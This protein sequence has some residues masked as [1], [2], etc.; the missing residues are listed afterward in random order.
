MQAGTM[1]VEE[2][3]ECNKG[4]GWIG[5]DLDGTLAAWT[6]WTRW[7][8]FGEPIAPMVDRVRAWV[9]DGHVVKIFTA[10]LDDG[11]RHNTC[12]K[13]GERFTPRQMEIAIRA[14]CLRHLGFELEVTNVKDMHMIM[15]YD[16]R[17]VQ[18][19]PNTGR[20]LAEEHAAELA[21]LRGAP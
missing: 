1:T 21:A 3:L 18:M 9:A 2:L 16:D 13:T 6:T 4:R 17:C 8:E 19:V 14:W 12:K 11:S 7:D 5:V 10:R 20:T 15:L